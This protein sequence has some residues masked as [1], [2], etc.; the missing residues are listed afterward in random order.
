[1]TAD[2]LGALGRWLRRRRPAARVPSEPWPDGW[3]P[4]CCTIALASD[5]MRLVGVAPKHLL[6]TVFAAGKVLARRPLQAHATECIEVAPAAGMAVRLEFSGHVVDA[7]GRQL[8]F[9]LN[10]GLGRHTGGLRRRE[11]R[12]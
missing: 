3:L 6:L 10:E 11:R 12:A 4:P 7:A 5:T 2:L 8:A 1:M 9:R